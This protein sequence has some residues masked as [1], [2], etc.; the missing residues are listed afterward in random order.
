MSAVVKKADPEPIVGL[1][2]MGFCALFVWLAISSGT[3]TI[4]SIIFTVVLSV[5]SATAFATGIILGAGLYSVEDK[6][7]ATP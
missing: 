2:L 1:F 4:A 7:G 5:L 6:K 3:D